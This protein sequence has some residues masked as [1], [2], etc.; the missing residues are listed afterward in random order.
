MAY[1]YND[2]Q[3]LN[4][5]INSTNN[6]DQKLKTK[7]YSLAK[8]IIDHDRRYT[9][10]ELEMVRNTMNGLWYI[11]KKQLKSLTYSNIIDNDYEEYE[12][13]GYND[14]CCNGQGD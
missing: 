9:K 11:T 8:N 12:E 3:H 5:L 14:Y 4:D 6:P 7:I 2:I 1:I 10:E 13:Y